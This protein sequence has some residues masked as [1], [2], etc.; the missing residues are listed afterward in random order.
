MS[1]LGPVLITLAFSLMIWISNSDK[2][3][4]KIAVID[5]SFAFQKNLPDNEFIRFYYP[6]QKLDEAR[7]DFYKTDFT[8]ILYI[9]YN[10]VQSQKSPIQLFFKKS[11]GLS[12]NQYLKNC[13]ERK[14]YEYKLA[15]NH[16]DP[17]VIRNAR[18]TIQIESFRQ[19]E[20]GVEK[21]SQNNLLSV[22][23]FVCGV[24]IFMFLTIY[25]TQVMRSV[26]EEKSNRV[27]EVIVSSVRPFQLMMG[28]I[29][30]VALV[31]IS[32]FAIWIAL[33]L[34]LTNFVSTSFFGKIASDALKREDQI[35]MVNKKGSNADF[36]KMETQDT[37]ME[38]MK[39]IGELK[40]LN[41]PEVILCFFLYFLA[42]YLFYSALFAA[43]GSAVDSEADTQQFILPI[44]I[45]LIIGYVMTVNVWQN[46]EGPMAIW[47][48]MIPFTSPIVMMAR[49]PTQTV[50]WYEIWISLGLLTL[51]FIFTTW[52]AARIYRTG[53]LM[54]G[55]KPSWKEIIKWVRYKA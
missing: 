42:G 49:I 54:Y 33:T 37:K 2:T 19:P 29:L 32:Q 5:A 24:L 26:M 31:G 13:L 17:E 18:Q 4:Q 8:C 51:G 34:V 22:V 9:P 55:K 6:N 50:H 43:V 38:A 14:L 23:G 21:K 52:L 12:V 27:V 30:G 10:I 47:G 36:K 45:P 3:E 41:I 44:T 53:I 11:P 46:P 7:R 40:D 28:K 16:I 20:I 35:E 1:I 48:S 25:G 15:A 39:M